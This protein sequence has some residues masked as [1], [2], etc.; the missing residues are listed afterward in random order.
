MQKDDRFSDTEDTKLKKFLTGGR[1]YSQLAVAIISALVFVISAAGISG[2]FHNCR[3]AENLKPLTGLDVTQDLDGQ[4]VKG[5][6]YKFL[7]EVGYIAQTE[8]AATHYYYLMYTDA[9]DGEQY[10]T[11]V[12]IPREQKEQMK[13]II[14]GFLSYVSDYANDPSTPYSGAAVQDMTGR[15]KTMS[16][17]EAEMFKQGV[18]T[19]GLE[20]EPQIGYTLKVMELPKK[21]DSVGYW[22]LCVPF[23]AA[24]VVSIILFLYGQKLERMREEQSKSPYPYQN[25]KK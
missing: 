7:A 3:E 16:K 15:F 13:T 6:A 9:A 14:S 8:A 2:I 17:S 5:A 23:G 19:L 21:S 12:E 25:R 11:L 20:R 4:Y 10:V 1:I 18:N 22:F 24:M